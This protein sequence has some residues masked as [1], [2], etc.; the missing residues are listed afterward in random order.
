MHSFLRTFAPYVAAALCG[1]D[2]LVFKGKLAALYSPNGMHYYLNVNHV[3]RK[4]FKTHAAEVTGQLLDASLVAAAKQFGRY[5]YI[6]AATVNKEKVALQFAA[7][8]HVKQGL[9]CV[10]QCVEPC[11]SFDTCKNA[12]GMLEVRGEPGKCSHLYHYYLHPKFGWMYVR[13]QTWFPFEIQ[14]GINGREWLAR[15]MDQEKLAYKRCDN[16]FLHIEDW[17]RAQQLLDRQLRTDWVRHLDA[18]QKEVHP[19]HPGHLGNLPLAYNW[20]VF[21]SEWATDIAFHS[22]GDLQPWCDRW[23]RQAFLSFGSADVLRFLGRTRPIRKNAAPEVHSNVC[24][25]EEGKR[26]KHFVQHNSVKLYTCHNV[27]RVET[28]IN[29]ASQMKVLRTKSNKPRGK[30]A[31]LPLRRGVADMPLRAE[32]S[33]QTN[34]RYLEAVASIKQTTT[35]KE[36][37]ESLTQRVDE[38][39]R[40]EAGQAKDRKRRLRGLNPLAS[41]DG[42]LLKMVSDPKWMVHGLRNRDVVG[43]LYGQ[44]QVQQKESKRRSARATRLLRLLRGHGVLQKVSGTHRYQVTEQGRAKVQ[45]LLAAFNANPDELTAKA[46]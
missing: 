3:L 12:N 10:L 39:Q 35:V 15:Q 18:L 8:H 11:W 46:A 24:E 37:A 42:A 17:Q 9:V 5:Q 4:D 40:N 1:F 16:K 25:F 13:L 22:A 19:A 43:W 41:T 32:V 26:I 31:M 36:L 34:D 33:Q 29:D 44:E 30:K 14:V 7:E 21:Q 28:T 23:L 2:R 20:T 27:V 45:A 38:P 6:R